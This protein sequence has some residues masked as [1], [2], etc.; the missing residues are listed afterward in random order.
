MYH[1][2]H[3]PVQM[4]LC[5][6]D[7]TKVSPIVFLTRPDGA[8]H[9]RSYQSV[10]VFRVPP[11]AKWG[12]RPSNCQS[13]ITYRV[14]LHAQAGLC[15]LEV[16]KVLILIGFPPAQVGLCALEATKVPLF[17]VARWGFARSKL[18]MRRYLM[19]PR[20][21]KWDLRSRNCQSV[22]IYCVPPP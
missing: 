19:F 4:G 12:L 11:M 6:L 1:A 5:T 16:T 3:P 13:E 18:P 2:P 10:S 22:T 15:A 21:P 8:L 9:P 14:P 20:L 7:V 17:I